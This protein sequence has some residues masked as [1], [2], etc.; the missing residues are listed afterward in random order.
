[1]GLMSRIRSHPHEILTQVKDTPFNFVAAF[2]QSPLSSVWGWWE[3]FFV[4]PKGD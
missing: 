1:M 4:F 2:F 3:R